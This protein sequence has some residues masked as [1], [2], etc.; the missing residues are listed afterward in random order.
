MDEGRLST[1]RQ[2]S[3]DNRFLHHRAVDSGFGSYILAQR[4]R[5]GTWTPRDEDAIGSSAEEGGLRR[6]VGRKALSDTMEASLGAAFVSASGTADG[7]AKVLQMGTQLGVCFGGTQ[8]W[9][10]RDGAR[11]SLGSDG[12]V[13][14]GEVPPGLREL[15]EALGYQFKGKGD[16]LLQVSGGESEGEA[17]FGA[18]SLSLDFCPHVAGRH[19]QELHGGNDLLVRSTR[20]SRR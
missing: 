17:S 19:A 4:F 6:V 3:I 2:N 8:V 16:L 9:G 10:E 7:L 13:E 14:Q 1:L 11:R 12:T 20:V 15:Q 5:T 18:D